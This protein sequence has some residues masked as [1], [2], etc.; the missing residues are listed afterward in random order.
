MELDYQV[1]DDAN[2]RD[3]LDSLCVGLDEAVTQYA[4]D[5]SPGALKRFKDAQADL[6]EVRTFWR[7]KET[8]A[9]RRNFLEIKE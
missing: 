8:I 3:L 6:Y 5:K 7:T 9:G 4:T 2:L 1:L